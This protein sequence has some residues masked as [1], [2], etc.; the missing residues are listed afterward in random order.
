MQKGKK[1]IKI[2][3]GEK[4]LSFFGDAIKEFKDK[5]SEYQSILI[6]ILEDIIN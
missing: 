3:K 5:L 6:E 4:S 2:G 1:V